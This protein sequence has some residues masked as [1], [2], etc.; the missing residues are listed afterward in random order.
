[1]GQRYLR[2]IRVG[3]VALIEGVEIVGACVS[4]D[5]RGQR[6]L[7]IGESD[8]SAYDDAV[9]LKLNQAGWRWTLWSWRRLRWR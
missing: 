4:V 7:S 2:A 9:E 6:R 8:W 1:M 3:C 5:G